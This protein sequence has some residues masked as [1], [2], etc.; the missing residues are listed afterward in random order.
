M[1]L[2]STVQHKVAGLQPHKLL[3]ILSDLARRGTQGWVTV[4]GQETSKEQAPVAEI[5]QVSS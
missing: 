3:G 5:V 2:C 4:L 1:A